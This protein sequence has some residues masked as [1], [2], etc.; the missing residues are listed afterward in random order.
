MVSVV[1][2][3]A[4]ER[5]ITTNALNF[6]FNVL[7]SPCKK[8]SR[9]LNVKIKKRSEGK[10]KKDG[11]ETKSMSYFALTIGGTRVDNTI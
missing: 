7:R 1:E 8:Q 11:F 4:K 9:S 10:D 3:G 6:A 2:M 5:L